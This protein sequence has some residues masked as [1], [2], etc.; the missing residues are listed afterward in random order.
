M[1]CVAGC[2]LI[3]QPA[4]ICRRIS[5]TGQYAALDE[6]QT[7]EENLRMI[8]QLT[9][10]SRHRAAQRAH[11]LLA[12]FDLLEASNRTVST[13]SGGMRRRLDLAASL[14]GDPEIIFLDEPTTG[15]D[16]RS[17]QALWS[18]IT[19]LAGSGV[20][21]FL[22]TQYLEE[23]DQLADRIAVIDGG[24]IVATG[25]PAELKQQISG[26]R[27]ALTFSD[28]ITFEEGARMLGER[29]LQIDR[30]SRTIAVATDGSAIAVRDLLD[31]IDP[32]RRGIARF[33]VKTATLDDV[34]LA[35]TGHHAVTEEELLHV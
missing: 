17:R 16:L 7:G 34:F 27:L 8:G 23:A 11:E 19:R 10:L 5:L 15:L 30:D 25:T 33:D 20:T 4:E 31:E 1:A 9:G 35:L 32:F 29:A 18:V 22:T 3:T 12:Q 2:D 26:S 28:N 14:L 24:H 13:Y 6:L 21:F